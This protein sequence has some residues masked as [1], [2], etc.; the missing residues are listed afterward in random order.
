MSDIISAWVDRDEMRRLAESLIPHPR[1][2]W[3]DRLEIDFGSSFEGFT[4]VSDVEA[5]T[6]QSSSPRVAPEPE[7]VA[8][9][10]NGDLLRNTVTQ[11]LTPTPEKEGADASNQEGEMT[12]TVRKSALSSLKKA[13]IEGM[14]GGVI[15]SADVADRE[16]EN[17]PPTPVESQQSPPVTAKPS[18]ASPFRR[19]PLSEST[20]APPLTSPV[21]RKLVRPAAPSGDDPI[22]A[23]VHR[24]GSWLKNAVGV[25]KFFISNLEGKIL[26]DEVQN[27]K[28]IQVARSLTT[29]STSNAENGSQVGSLHVRIGEASILEVVPTPSQ[30]GTLI[31][32]L[33]L[34]RSLEEESVREVRLGLQ[35][36]ADARLI[37]ARG[38]KR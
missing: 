23:R 5:S 36:A 6:L 9:G 2:S 22:L 30:F 19:V 32:G 17:P 25:E 29:A 20:A 38:R 37:R 13:Q 26:V 18:L 12:P 1:S 27:P 33:I 4:R 15:R 10:L 3:S 24:Y 35:E 28:L 16:S 34:E 8:V 14:A 21:P 11:K 7:Q 31:L